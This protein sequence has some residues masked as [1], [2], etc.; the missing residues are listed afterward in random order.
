MDIQAIARN[1]E[2]FEIG[3][4]EDRWGARLAGRICALIGPGGEVTMG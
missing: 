1:H 2:L 4:K 3:R